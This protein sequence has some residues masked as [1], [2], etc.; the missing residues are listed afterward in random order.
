MKAIITVV[1]KDKAGIVAGV[2][3]KIAEFGLN[4][5]DISQTVLDDFFTMMAVVSSDEKQD[6]TKL[7]SEFE[8]YGDTLNVKI[9][10]QSATIFDAMY[11]I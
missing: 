10:I 4:I 1:G 11:N 9:N 3:A 2:S 8:A 6:F 7:R 5:D